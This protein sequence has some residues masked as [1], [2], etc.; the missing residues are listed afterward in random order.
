MTCEAKVFED[1]NMF[2]YV[3]LFLGFSYDFIIMNKR[4]YE[5]VK[6]FIT[7]HI[8]NHI[9]NHINDDMFSLTN[10]YDI[11]IENMMCMLVATGN[12][13]VFEQIH[14]NLFAQIHYNS[15]SIVDLEYICA[16]L[17]RCDGII[18]LLFPSCRF[19]PIEIYSKIAQTKHRTNINYFIR[20]MRHKH[21]LST[22][23]FIPTAICDMSDDPIKYL[24]EYDAT[25]INDENNIRF[26]C[27][28]AMSEKNPIALSRLF[29]I[30][31]NTSH[32]SII[33]Q[34]CDLFT[35][36]LNYANE[37]HNDYSFGD[38][39]FDDDL[40]FDDEIDH[41][42]DQYNFDGEINDM[43]YENYFD[44]EQYYI[45]DGENNVMHESDKL[46]DVAKILIDN[47]PLSSEYDVVECIGHIIT[48]CFYNQEI[49]YKHDYIDYEFIANCHNNNGI[50]LLDYCFQV[51]KISLYD[52]CNFVV[53]SKDDD[54]NDDYCFIKYMQ[55]R[56]YITTQTCPTNILY[57][58]ICNND[59]DKLNLLYD[60]T[61]SSY[62]PSFDDVHD[63]LDMMQNNDV[64]ITKSIEKFMSEKFPEHAKYIAS[65]ESC[66]YDDE[67]YPEYNNLRD[68]YMH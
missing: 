50:K 33:M 15:I 68:K 54:D 42:N 67:Y 10:N 62:K 30:T 57:E 34:C 4:S 61:V 16:N 59:I 2:M 22:K 56:Q 29:K 6:N 8:N 45:I 3:L 43:Q 51:G 24:C 28:H 53:K 64:Y 11:S 49:S 58:L 47:I 35:S 46:Y 39:Y 41:N 1:N 36:I 44:D 25:A 14:H 17:I 5:T 31:D 21:N 52:V 40:Y 48:S 7:K 26:C 23:Y 38:F 37:M 63:L 20:L 32:L 12:Y 55:E 18:D 66:I 60:Y 27:T 13:N 19:N 9:N 65:C